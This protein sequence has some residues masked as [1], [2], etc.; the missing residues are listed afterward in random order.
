MS[1]KKSLSSLQLEV[2]NVLWNLGKATV[3]Q[4]QNALEPRKARTTVATVLGRLEKQGF[5]SHEKAEVSH[6][7]FPLVAREQV[8]RTMVSKLVDSLFKGDRS[9]LVNHLLDDLN[10]K[11]ED[12]NQAIALIKAYEERRQR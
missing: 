6:H 4:V 2:M 7:Y 12:L 9:V 5:V 11:D 1:Q 3:A 10:P 8:Q